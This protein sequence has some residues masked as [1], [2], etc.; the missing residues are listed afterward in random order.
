[1]KQKPLPRRPPITI[2][3]PIQEPHQLEDMGERGAML[4]ATRIYLEQQLERPP[5]CGV[6]ACASWRGSKLHV[7]HQ[8]FRRQPSNLKSHRKCV[9]QLVAICCVVSI[10]SF[11]SA[12][13]PQVSSRSSSQLN[14]V[15]LLADPVHRGACHKPRVPRARQSSSWGRQGNP[16]CR[17]TMVGWGWWNCGNGMVGRWWGLLKL[18]YEGVL[19]FLK[20]D[21]LAV[22]KDEWDTR[23]EHG[24]GWVHD[25]SV[26]QVCVCLFFLV[27]TAVGPP[28]L[29]MNQGMLS[30][31]WNQAWTFV[32][33]WKVPSFFLAKFFRWNTIF[34]AWEFQMFFRFHHWGKWSNLIHACV[35]TLNHQLVSC[36]R[37]CSWA[38]G[39][40]PERLPYQF[41]A[42]NE[43]WM[44]MVTSNLGLLKYE[45]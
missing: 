36:W 8:C 12:C 41:C 16:A 20:W 29:A 4:K 10:V 9:Y 44:G 14:C 45:G 27:T 5:F 35:W 7:Y 40:D 17:V 11:L 30:M 38:V 32:K 34:Q 15:E 18:H 33:T 6:P 39:R 19:E 25:V 21:N 3:N 43:T 42:H 37:C 1:M 2:Y 31:P 13:S 23:M 22:S 24:K 28:I 26:F